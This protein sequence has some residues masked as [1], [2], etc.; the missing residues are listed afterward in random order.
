MQARENCIEPL[1]ACITNILKGANRPELENAALKAFL[2][3]SH[4]MQV[5]AVKFFHDWK[6]KFKLSEENEQLL[7]DFVGTRAKRFGEKT[8]EF[9]KKRKIFGK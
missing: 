7:V 4:H 8:V 2:G 9:Q 6:P 1:Q 3:A 5:Q